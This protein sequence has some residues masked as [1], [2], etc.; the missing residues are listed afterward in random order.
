MRNA[1]AL[2]IVILF[3]IAVGASFLY[4]VWR[5]SRRRMGSHSA[6]GSGRSEA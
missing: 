2:L 6:S 5:A 4:M 3:T 1:G